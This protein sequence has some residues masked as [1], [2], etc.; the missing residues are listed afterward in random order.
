LHTHYLSI[1]EMLLLASFICLVTQAQVP[2]VLTQAQVMQ[3]QVPLVLTQTQVPLMLTQFG[4][5][6]IALQ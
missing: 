4:P 3:A 1:V 2:L 5:P 6:Q